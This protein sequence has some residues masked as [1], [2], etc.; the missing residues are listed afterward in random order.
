MDTGFHKQG[1]KPIYENIF[2]DRPV[3]KKAAKSLLIIGGHGTRFSAVQSSF[4][5][6]LSAGIGSVTVLLPESVKKVTGTIPNCVFLP[7]NKSGAFAANNLDNFTSYSS[8]AD[9]VLLMGEIS[10]NDETISLFEEFLLK[11]EKPL[12]ISSEIIGT[13]ASMPTALFAHDK[14]LYMASLITYKKLLENLD[15]PSSL[16][17]EMGVINKVLM[18][19]KLAQLHPADYVLKDKQMVVANSKEAS[20]TDL[21]K[22]IPVG[23]VDGVSVTFWLQHE[24]KYQALTTAANVLHNCGNSQEI[25]SDIKE[26]LSYGI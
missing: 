26:Q 17:P 19:K 25:F 11:C 20:V 4:Q 16:K 24:K 3:N 9:G 8:E 6:V 10:N 22:E 7:S 1:D 23:I 14:R 12:A 18:L 5:A 2:W 15:L 21:A 13:F